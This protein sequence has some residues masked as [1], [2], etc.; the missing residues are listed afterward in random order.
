MGKGVSYVDT[1]LQ[2]SNIRHDVLRLPMFL[3]NISSFIYHVLPVSFLNN[4][5]F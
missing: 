1:L 2:Q 3:E 4:T 5:L